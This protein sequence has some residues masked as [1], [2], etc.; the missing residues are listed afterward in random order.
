MILDVAGEML[1]TLNYTVITAQNGPAA[2]EMY[3]RRQEN[4]D[5]IIL[6]M[7][8]PD[9]GGGEVFDTIKK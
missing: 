8:M 3:Q 7:V 4:I 2:I 6:D 1:K 9:M 5:L